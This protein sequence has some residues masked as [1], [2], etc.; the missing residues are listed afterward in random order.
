MSQYGLAHD[1]K[2]FWR[3]RLLK[4]TLHASIGLTLTMGDAV[5]VAN[6]PAGLDAYAA[7]LNGLYANYGAVAGRFPGA[8]LLGITINLSNLGECIDIEQGDAVPAQAPQYVSERLAAGVARP[9][10]YG[11]I[12]AMPAIVGYLN[13]AGFSRSQYRLW[14]AHYTYAHICGPTTCRYSGGA[15]PQ[16]DATQWY[17]TSYDQS[18]LAGD[19]FGAAPVPPPPPPRSSFTS[20]AGG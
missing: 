2:M 18:L 17:S 12:S 10:L 8:H 13:G 15:T 9:V 20:V 3:L 4:R 11:S 19:F 16:C 6:L 14:A 7:Y 1:L 5:T